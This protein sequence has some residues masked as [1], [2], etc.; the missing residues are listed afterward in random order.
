MNRAAY[1]I[2]RGIIGIFANGHF[3]FTKRIVLFFDYCRLIV[4][5]LRLPFLP[6]LIDASKDKTFRVNSLNVTIHYPNIYSFFFLFTE[7]FCIQ[8]YSADQNLDTYIDLGA[9]I[10]MSIL[11]YYR[12]NPHV[13]IYAFEPNPHNYAY[14]LK[15]IRA[16]NIQHC[17]VYQT[18]VLDRR[19]KIKY[20]EI[21]DNIQ[22]LDSGLF[23]NQKLPFRTTYVK[24]E[25]L[26]GLLKKIADV[27][28]LKVDI[29][30]SE[31]LVFK[32][33]FATKT[34][35]HM[36]KIICESHLFTQSNRKSHQEVLSKLR[37]LGTVITRSNSR[38]TTLDYWTRSSVKNT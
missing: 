2:I 28:L 3:S 19:S 15:N 13:K 4:L 32:D 24:T 31:Y 9:Y 8:E 16:N 29:E 34:I 38:L 12:L 14:L 23:L 37:A 7:I 21:L 33:L 18:A 6:T 26:S 10:G 11:W 20:Y 22:N 17:H 25:K 5:A 30:G 35:L 1:L 27:S 36:K